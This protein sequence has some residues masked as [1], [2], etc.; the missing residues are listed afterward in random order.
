MFKQVAQSMLTRLQIAVAGLA[1]LIL[2]GLGTSVV[3]GAP[4]TE[5]HPGPGA[6]P[7]DAVDGFGWDDAGTH[8]PAD[9]WADGPRQGDD[10]H[11]HDAHHHDVDGW[12]G[13][14]H[15][16]NDTHPHVA[17]G[18]DAHDHYHDDARYGDDHY[19]DDDAHHHD[20]ARYPDHPEQFDP[21][22]H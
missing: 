7:A 6:A 10:R 1:V 13:D 16:H 15:Y 19:H 21:P 20:D 11:P 14:D 8:H 2:L 22:C 18:H 9:H 12:D 3:I 5:R 4:F 17:D